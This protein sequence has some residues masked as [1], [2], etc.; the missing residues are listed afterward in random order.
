MEAETIP[1]Q[2]AK[3]RWIVPE[4]RIAIRMILCLILFLSIIDRWS[5]TEDLMENVSS[6]VNLN[7]NYAKEID[8]ETYLMT[9]AQLKQLFPSS[10]HPPLVQ[11]EEKQTEIIVDFSP[12][13]FVV[14]LRNRGD[15]PAWGRLR[16][17]S[18]CWCRGS[19]IEGREIPVQFLA[20]RMNDFEVIILAASWSINGF[21][22]ENE[23]SPSIQTEWTALYTS[24]QVEK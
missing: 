12:L 13:Y 23:S 10:E 1:I 8:V 17:H 14:R 4:C 15:L 3:R 22:G 7:P 5:K 18:K 16:A 21:E 11:W 24:K 20:P 19:G 9:R 6:N 2:K